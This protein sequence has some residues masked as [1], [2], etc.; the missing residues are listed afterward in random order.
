MDSIEPLDEQRPAPRN[1]D[2]VWNLLTILMLLAV[3]CVLLVFGL[4][5]VN[6]NQAFNPFKP[7]ALPAEIVI[8]TS[9]ATVRAFPATWT[10]TASLAPT[11]TN[12]PGPSMP[13][14]TQF[15]ITV[16]PNPAT[17]TAVALATPTFTPTVNSNFAFSLVSPPASVASTV[18][19]PEKGCNWTGIGG[20]VKDL[21]GA[22]L[23]GSIVRLVGFFDNSSVD[24]TA[25]TGT[26]LQYGPSGYEFPLGEKP[27]ASKQQ[28]WIQLYDQA[29][30]PLSEKVYL[31]TFAEC[32][33]NLTLVNFKQVK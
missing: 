20:Q 8:P 1:S 28:L 26:V 15:V 19:Y 3:A 21:Q 30:L 2:M 11:Q 32:D 14:A 4:L 29:G 9:T 27:A 25:M 7:P 17:Q 10:A 33:K 22:P 12:T 5:F 16:P 23:V 31:D 6:P 24:L 13:T 18:I